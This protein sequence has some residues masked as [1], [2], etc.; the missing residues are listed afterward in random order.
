MRRK[1]LGV[2]AFGTSTFMLR[3]W[4]QRPQLG[5]TTLTHTHDVEGMG[6]RINTHAFKWRLVGNTSLAKHMPSAAHVH[7]T[8]DHDKKQIYL[9]R[10]RNT[11]TQNGYS[12]FPSL[13]GY[14]QHEQYEQQVFK[15]FG[16]YT[17]ARVFDSVAKDIAPVAQD[18][19]PCWT[20][21]VCPDGRVRNE[22]MAK[23][24][25]LYSGLGFQGAGKVCME[26]NFSFVHQQTKEQGKLCP[27]FDKYEY[28]PLPEK[29]A[30]SKSLFLLAPV[31]NIPTL[32]W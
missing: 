21:K 1:L 5:V 19:D 4:H 6:T 3:R 13:V 29:I 26:G 16:T 28:G 12:K 23:L 17:L 20:I 30:I 10:W 27:L 31:A 15:R 25:D 18:T 9:Q 8:V 24:I 7:L 2:V 11:Y 32:P 22:P 14:S